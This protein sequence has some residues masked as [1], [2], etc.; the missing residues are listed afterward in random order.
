MRVLGISRVSTKEQATDAH[1]SFL[2]QRTR[3]QEYVAA[4]HGELV[5]IVEYV[6]S[7]GSNRRELREILARV[8]REQIECIVVNELDRLARDMVSTML[9]LEDLQR[10]GCRFASVSDDLDLTTPD[11]ELKMMMLAMFAHYFRRQLSRKVKGGQ[12]ERAKQGKRHGERP[13]GYRADGDYWAIE[14]D[15]AA[16]VRQV[17]HW[18]LNDHLGFRA[19]AKRLNA[20]GVL[21]QKGR[22]GTW[23][24]RTVE[25]MLRR[26]AY[27][28]DTIYQ[29]WIQQPD[30]EGHRHLKRNTPQVVR[31][32]HPAIIDRSTWN[33]AQERLAVR[34]SLGRR[35]HDSPYLLSG[36]VRCG[37]CGGSMV[38]LRTGRRGT[39]GT[40]DPVYCCRAYHTKGLCSTATKIPLADL[41]DAVLWALRTELTHAQEQ[42]TPDQ[43][44]VW[45]GDDPV[46]VQA[47]AERRKAEQRLT[48]IPS[49]LA[50]AEEMTLQGA[51]TIDEYRTTKQRLEEERE[52]LQ[53]IVNQPLPTTA[54]SGAVARRLQQLIDHYED[55]LVGN[56][57]EG[58]PW[59][60]GL[61]D[62][63]VCYP[64]RRIEVTWRGSLSASNLTNFLTT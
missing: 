27:A 52:R 13:Y 7:G 43:V 45:L 54:D 15:E 3:I 12:A 9:F 57:A 62:T 6:Q 4:R 22:L 28:G 11:G 58:R 47:Q 49:M 36:L 23:D 31:D 51:Y 32:T 33:A 40:R 50:R 53:G 38:V 39:D 63:V 29:K 8:E 10:V 41:E 37:D 44:A 16:I 64:E 19:I 34:K 26:E 2:A 42:P 55:V 5:D 25:R 20:Q 60:Q 48:A 14:A 18:Y 30:R 46:V 35:T 1:F 21:G 61:I 59:V 17:Y 24:A 56:P